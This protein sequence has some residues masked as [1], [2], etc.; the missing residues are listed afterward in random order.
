M[1]HPARNQVELM[2]ESYPRA[3]ITS[4]YISST[5]LNQCSTPQ[6]ACWP[7]QGVT[8][9]MVGRAQTNSKVA[10]SSGNAFFLAV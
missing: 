1:T 7:Q 8:L 4:A 10:L 9:S 6:N 3:A 5:L 2:D